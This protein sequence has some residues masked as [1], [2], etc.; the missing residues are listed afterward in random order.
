MGH[1]MPIGD[2]QLVPIHDAILNSKK[3]RGGANSSEMSKIAAI[4]AHIENGNYCKYLISIGLLTSCEDP[5]AAKPIMRP[6]PPSEKIVYKE[7]NYVYDL[8]EDPY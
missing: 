7:S 8:N 2:M 6:P 3:V 5:V 1:P 4:K